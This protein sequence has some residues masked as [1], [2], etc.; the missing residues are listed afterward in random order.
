VQVVS[1]SKKCKWCHLPKSAS[2]VIFQKV[3]MVS[4]SKKCKWCHLPKS[5]NGVIFQKV[6]MVSSSKKVQM[7]LERGTSQRIISLTVQII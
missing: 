6:Q 5:A 7:L 3:Q 4:S 1:S 2:G